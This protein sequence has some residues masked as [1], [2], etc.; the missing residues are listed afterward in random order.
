MEFNQLRNEIAEI[1][2]SLAALQT[3]S[4]AIEPAFITS[5]SPAPDGP[6][7][8]SS[9]VSSTVVNQQLDC[10]DCHNQSPDDQ[11]SETALLQI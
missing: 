8:G 1:D 3:T 11:T 2:N 6:L 4:S 7:P 10:E 5:T 9:H